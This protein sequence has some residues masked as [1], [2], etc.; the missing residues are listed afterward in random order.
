MLVSNETLCSVPGCHI[1]QWENLLPFVPLPSPASF[2]HL[3]PFSVTLL[4]SSFC[5][6]CPA[7]AQSFH[8]LFPS[9]L[10]RTISHGLVKVTL[11]CYKQIHRG[12]GVHPCGHCFRLAADS[13][14]IA[15]FAYTWFRFGK[16]SLPQPGL[17]M[18]VVFLR[19]AEI[20]SVACGPDPDCGLST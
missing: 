9:C 5:I 6:F 18:Y 7:A 14:A 11:M 3:S 4:C 1:I 15:A 10:L 20:L 13:D 16:F 12:Q 2:L 19:E 17:A 8:L